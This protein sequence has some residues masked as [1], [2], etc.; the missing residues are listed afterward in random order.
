MYSTILSLS[1]LIVPLAQSSCLSG[2][3]HMKRQAVNVDTFG[4]VGANGPFLW[5][6]LPDSGICERGDFQ[7][8]VNLGMLS[9]IRFFNP[10]SIIYSDSYICR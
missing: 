10:E 5:G 9:H 8:P 1:A 4:Y 7:S 2:H 6:N 3:Y